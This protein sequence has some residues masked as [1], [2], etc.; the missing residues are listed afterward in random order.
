MNDQEGVIKYRLQHHYGNLPIT[1]DINPINAWRSLL[2]KLK[3]IGQ[4]PEKYQGLGYGNISLR[5]QPDRRAFLI[6]GTQTGH[7][8]CLKAEHFAIVET[9]SPIENS[10]HSI[11]PCKP[12]S[13]AL[14]HASVYQHAPKAQA[15]IHV[16]CPEIWH[17][18]AKLQLPYTAAQIA[19]GTVEMAN[20]VERLFTSG[21]LKYMPIFCMLGH[22]DGI[23]SFGESLQSAAITL[24]AQ[25]ANA[26][27][28]E[29][30]ID[31]G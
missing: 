12:S 15:V 10:I 1:T 11:G 9:A 19:Y 17:N 5:M 14:T 26:L 13:E 7:L 22:E 27:A 2:Y 30:S 29:Q 16:H 31:A 28:I 21:Q 4:S 18:T 3:L 6:S 24:L 8:P 25:L 20:A 23:V